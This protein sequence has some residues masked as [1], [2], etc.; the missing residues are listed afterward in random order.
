MP[1]EVWVQIVNEADANGDG[2]VLSLSSY[3]M[4][5]FKKLC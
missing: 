3:P 2:E 1:A 5:N 4:M